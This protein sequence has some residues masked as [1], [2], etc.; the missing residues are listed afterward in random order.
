MTFIGLNICC[1]NTSWVLAETDVWLFS[2]W[3][4]VRLWGIFTSDLFMA[5]C[6]ELCFHAVCDFFFVSCVL[7]ERQKMPLSSAYPSCVVTQGHGGARTWVTG[8]RRTA[9]VNH[10]RE[11]HGTTAGF[12]HHQLTLF[13]LRKWH[14]WVTHL[15]QYD[16]ASGCYVCWDVLLQRHGCSSHSLYASESKF[17][18]YI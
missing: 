8:G 16:A 13:F 5:L 6:W 4:T 17:M 14:V 7:W 2:C 9:R 3:V 11:R 12:F 1:F 10:P 18:T 15:L